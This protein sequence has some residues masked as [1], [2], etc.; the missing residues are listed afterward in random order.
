MDQ[1]TH[2]A[3]ILKDPKTQKLVIAESSGSMTQRDGGVKLT[4]IENHGWWSDKK[5]TRIFAYPKSNA[6]FGADDAFVSQL[7]RDVG[8]D[9][10]YNGLQYN[11]SDSSFADYVIGKEGSGIGASGASRFGIQAHK[12]K[13]YAKNNSYDMSDEFRKKILNTKDEDL[14]NII[15]DTSNNADIERLARSVLFSDTYS[16]FGNN[17]SFAELGHPFDYFL[18][19]HAYNRGLSRALRVMKF[20]AGDP[21]LNASEALNILKNK[22]KSN[23]EEVGAN[24]LSARLKAYQFEVSNDPSK[25]KFLKGWSNRAIGLGKLYGFIYDGKKFKYVPEISTLDNNFNSNMAWGKAANGDASNMTAEAKQKQ[26]NSLSLYSGLLKGDNNA[27]THSLGGTDK[28][29]RILKGTTKGTAFSTR[30]LPVLK[31][32][33]AEQIQEALLH[34]ELNGNKDVV[35]A[36]HAL[37]DLL[38]TNTD[39][40][41]E[42]GKNFIFNVITN[43]S[44][45]SS[46]HST[47]GI[48]GNASDKKSP[49]KEAKRISTGF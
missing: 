15:K 8:K 12:L 34:P 7:K 40:L 2:I 1:P 22:A 43:A 31:D 36:I 5:F 3:L 27:L 49:G 46:S 10:S 48:G 16:K 13:S 25:E 9:S 23:P 47:M 42:N 19:D 18:I 45:K 20:A 24:I 4:P 26:L 35:D 44:T 38:K 29:E 17:S 14:V 41:T 32:K 30:W 21:Y 39:K 33:T 28:F 37:G 11:V 6:I